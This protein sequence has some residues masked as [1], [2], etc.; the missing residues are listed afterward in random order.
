MQ[1]NACSVSDDGNIFQDLSA[2][3]VPL[4]AESR[5]QS[6]GSKT[7]DI[8]FLADVIEAL[9]SECL[10]FHKQCKS[11]YPVVGGSSW[12]NIITSLDQENRMSLAHVLEQS[13]VPTLF[14]TPRL[15]D[16]G[17]L[18]SKNWSLRNYIETRLIDFKYTYNLGKNVKTKNNQ[19]C[20]PRVVLDF[21]PFVY[22]LILPNPKANQSDDVIY[23][24]EWIDVKDGVRKDL[25]YNPRIALSKS[26][27]AINTPRDTKTIFKEMIKE[28]MR[29]KFG[30]KITN[31][32][33]I[34]QNGTGMNSNQYIESFIAF[35]KKVDD[36]RFMEDLG[37]KGNVQEL[38][39]TDDVLAVL[40]YDMLHDSLFS[41]NNL[42]FS[43]PTTT[44]DMKGT[45]TAARKK[46]FQKIPSKFRT[47]SKTFTFKSKFKDEFKKLEGNVTYNGL[48]GKTIVQTSIKTNGPWLILKPAQGVIP[49]LFKT[50]GDLSQYVYAAQYNTVVATGDRMG[51]GA[52]LYIN[53]K[54]NRKVKCMI[55]D[56]ATGFVIYSGFSTLNFRGR[57][58]CNVKLNNSQ[59]CLRTTNVNS[60]TVANRLREA[61][62]DQE[63]LEKMIRNKPKLPPGLRGLPNQ[64]IS[65]ANATNTT[66]ANTIANS[67]IKFKDYWSEDDANKLVKAYSRLKNKISNNSK[68]AGIETVINSV[69]PEGSQLRS[70]REGGVRVVNNGSPIAMNATQ[71]P[72]SKKRSRN[73]ATPNQNRNNA[74]PTQNQASAMNVNLTPKQNLQ[75][76]LNN[77]RFTRLT[78]KNKNVFLGLLNRDGSN[79][80]KIKK[81]AVE[82][83][84]KRELNRYLNTKQL[85]DRQKTII[86]NQI[87]KTSLNN[88]VRMANNFEKRRSRV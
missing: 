59:A 29:M 69:L 39:M 15:C 73:N 6:P 14:N 52:G 43:V 47:G 68:R 37:N 63:L 86:R 87:S 3:D 2:F 27:L 84:R 74:T 4:N 60:K 41:K 24:T 42:P 19:E 71:T 70:T 12:K 88:L 16:P 79:L 57:S 82:L 20:Y 22:K 28:T 80:N 30:S 33:N 8:A 44:K 11:Q 64:W 23:V 72:T 1:R 51:V 53:A 25:G 34:S 85:T 81:N 45:T 50:L 26:E 49:A 76:Y 17:M 55:E 5:K 21:R 40:Y 35:L 75:A 13:G 58:S 78:P 65:S 7:F 32:R 61:A 83:Q 66:T 48:V 36:I 46:E 10:T 62:P 54:G 38:K 31:M 18:V 67:I 56:A 9:K 77:A